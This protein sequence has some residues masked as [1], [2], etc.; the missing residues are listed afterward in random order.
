MSARWMKSRLSVIVSMAIVLV[1]ISHSV[2][3]AGGA[4]SSACEFLN[5][6]V[7]S[8]AVGMGGAYSAITDDPSANYWNPAGLTNNESSALMLQHNEHFQDIQHEYIAYAAPFG[9]RGVVGVSVSY[10]HMGTILGY[11]ANDVPTG[12]FKVYDI[13]YG[14]SYGH[15]ITENLRIGCGTK[16]IQQSLSDLKASG[17]AFDIGMLYS[18]RNFNTSLVAANFGTAVKYESEKFA[19]PTEYRLGLG[20]SPYSSPLTLAAEYGYSK[21]GTER[22]AFGAEYNL[23]EHFSLRSGFCPG[24]INNGDGKYSLG[25]GVEV[26]GQKIDYTFLPNTD[27]GS[28]HRISATITFSEFNR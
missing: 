27:L 21:D 7:G 3:N 23:I 9:S 13:A 17:W 25:C 26:W 12:E 20:Y 28:S 11:D 24:E 16:Y 18:Y 1:L 14:L 2:S 8:R 15:S 4:G 22:M 10:L 5:I 19:L 6:G